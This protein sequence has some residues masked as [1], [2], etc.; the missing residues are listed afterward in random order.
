[1]TAASSTRWISSSQ[2]A[3]CPICGRS[4]DGSCSINADG[5]LLSCHYGASHHPPAGM[6]PGDVIDGHDGQQYAFTGDSKDGRTAMFTPNKPRDS[7]RS[8][9]VSIRRKP[10]PAAPAPATP[11]PLPAKIR[12]ARLSEPA[13]ASSS[14]YS[15]SDTQRVL[16]IDAAD[17][18]K[19]FRCEHL[20]NG[21]W[22]RGAGPDP[23][24]AW[25]EAEA[26][27]HGVRAWVIDGEG[28]K[29]AGICRTGGAVA[30]TQPGHAHRPEQIQPRYERLERAAVL[31]VVFL[32][33]NDKQGEA[34]ARQAAEAAAAAGLPFMAVRAAAVWDGLP[35]G[36]SIDDVEGDPVEL[37]AD[38]ERYANSL[39]QAGKQPQE[40]QPDVVED[41]EPGEDSGDAAESHLLT[42][43][44]RDLLARI[45]ALA[46]CKADPHP[47]S[48]GRD[49]KAIWWRV[50]AALHHTDEALVDDWIEWCRPLAEFNEDALR[51]S[52]PNYRRKRWEKGHP[53][54]IGTLQKLAG[55]KSAQGKAKS[56]ARKL[57]HSKAMKCMERCIE[58]QAKGE[59]NSLRRRA[60][61]LKAAHDLKLQRYIKAQDIAQRVLEAKDGAAGN[62]FK[63]LSAA[64]RAAMPRP[65]LR[66]LLPGLIP[67]NDMTI[68][69]GRPKVG[70]TRLAVAIAAAVLRGESMLDLPAPSAAVP[71]VLVTDDQSDG[72]SADML[73]A[74]GMWNHPRLFWS[75][76]FRLTEEN[77]DALLDAIKANPGALVIIDSLRSIGRS[78][79]HGE[80][81]PEIGAVLYDLK[82][83]VMDAGGTLL[84][85]HHC[86]KAMD[87]V[88]VEALSGHNAISGAANTVLT[89]HYLPGV[90]NQPNK[91]IPDR[92]LVREGRSG[93][94]FDLVI[95]R[96][97][98]SFRKVG[99]M[100]KWQQQT[101]QAQKLEKLT[102]LQ[103]RVSEALV[104]DGGWMTRRQVCEAVGVEW[105]ERGRNGEP[106]KVGD[107]L[108]RLVELR[109]AESTRSGTESTYRCTCGAQ[110][111]TVTTVPTS[112]TNGSQCHGVDRDNRDKEEPLDGCHGC[113]EMDRDTENA[114]PDSLARL[115]RLS[116]PPS[117]SEAQPPLAPFAPAPVGSGSDVEADGDDPHWPP[118]SAEP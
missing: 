47:G 112:D 37:V 5:G 27:E 14:P 50:G 102:P 20:V 61:L 99:D 10:A 92:R 64:D 66:W 88:G 111:T 41:L 113:H 19:T 105:T 107:A 62:R 9:V 59:R 11:A 116:R 53:I 89:M 51:C 26:I 75:Q 18:S 44:A 31:G 28:E 78:L 115:S 52:W 63:A 71:V 33:D 29:V 16:R 6:K 58:V 81:D 83:A 76:S 56:N 85:I 118:R 67:A 2:R 80:N 77:I 38:I 72:D 42:A 13:A 25:H 101:Q 68:I 90:N 95:T 21:K 40:Q 103:Q 4:K 48:G 3:P 45:D 98:S 55:N 84:L 82:Q 23:W 36:G 46:A 106:R 69:G 1:M 8:K 73:E 104:D 108:T 114:G 100:E 117:A 94:G 86:N 79:Q 43:E 60:R 57:S 22:T 65:V 34:R 91:A 30:I 74:V 96:D 87:L 15:Y 54:T 97:G 93:E 109:A 12:L 49:T 17:G 32:V 39:L 35:A 70:K 110:E 7:A 24:P